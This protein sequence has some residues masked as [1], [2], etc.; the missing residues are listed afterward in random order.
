[1]WLAL[2]KVSLYIDEDAWRRF[3]EQVFAK[4]GTLRRLSGEVEKLI[5]S[6]DVQ[7][8]TKRKAPWYSAGS[9]INTR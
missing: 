6:E 1:M 9:K 2:T 5:S 7:P 8:N 3:R 4:H